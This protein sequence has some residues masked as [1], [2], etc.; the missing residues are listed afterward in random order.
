MRH[1]PT[2]IYRRRA[3]S[4]GNVRIAALS[5]YK[6]LTF[7]YSNI[8]ELNQMSP[9]MAMYYSFHTTAHSFPT[10]ST[11]LTV[12]TSWGSSEALEELLHLGCSLATKSWVDNH[13]SLILWKLAGMVCLEPNAE[14]DPSRKRWTW[15]NVVKQLLYR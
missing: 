8:T 5:S 2:I 3:A 6:P 13:W 10:P 4:S 9:K 1:D 14:A 12:P 7:I 11:S 15:A